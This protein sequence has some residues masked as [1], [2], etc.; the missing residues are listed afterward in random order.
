MLL[1]RSDT[2]EI[3][4]AFLKVLDHIPEEREGTAH[5]CLVLALFQRLHKVL[6]INDTARSEIVSPLYRY[7]TEAQIRKR[8]LFAIPHCPVGIHNSCIS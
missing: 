8:V 6:H 4:A 7:E 3:C 1:M 2:I 5:I